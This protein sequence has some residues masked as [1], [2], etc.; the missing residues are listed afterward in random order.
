MRRAVLRCAVLCCAALCC[1]VLRCAVMCCAVLCYAVLCCAWGTCSTTICA[2][3]Y[4]KRPTIQVIAGGPEINP[5]FVGFGL[6][7][8]VTLLS[9]NKWEKVLIERFSR[10]PPF[11]PS[12]TGKQEISPNFGNLTEGK[13]SG[14]LSIPIL[15]QQ[16]KIW[17]YDKNAR[18]CVWKFRTRVLR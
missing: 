2:R 13:I 11:F 3:T 7:A 14:T 10:F 6:T 9:Q 1:A 15:E 8:A 4:I 16:R 17:K 12:K 5:H 18:F